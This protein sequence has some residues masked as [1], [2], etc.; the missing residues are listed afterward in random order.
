MAWPRSRVWRSTPSVRTPSRRASTSMVDPRLDPV[1]IFIGAEVIQ[2]GQTKI[3]DERRRSQPYGERHPD[4]RH[5][6]FDQAV[7]LDAQRHVGGVPTTRPA[8][9]HPPSRST[10]TRVR[11]GAGSVRL[12]HDDDGERQVRRRR[13]PHPRSWHPI[14]SC[15]RPPRTE[16]PSFLETRRPPSQPI[17]GDAGHGSDPGQRDLLPAAGDILYKR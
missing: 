9:R 14:E 16:T 6:L 15:G 8:R 2:C 3:V 1:S 7:H 10:C 11:A 5:G 13:Q 17:D 12:G 4:Q